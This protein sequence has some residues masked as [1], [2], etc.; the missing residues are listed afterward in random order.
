MK[1]VAPANT[2]PGPMP[3]TDSREAARIVM[4]EC[5]ALPFLPEL[6]ERGP[7]G[8]QQGRTLAMLADLPVDVSPRGWR[9]ADSP[10]RLAR[11]AVD[12]LD[13]DCDALE[14][15]DEQA[16]DP[17][18]EP[19]SSQRLLQVRV[20]GPWSLSAGFELPGGLPT[21]TDRGARRDVAESLAQ[22]VASRATEL[23]GRLRAGTRVI[24]DEPMLWRVAAGTVPAPSHFDP[25]RAVPA[26]QLALALCRFG[27]AL[28]AAGVDHV[29]L[30]VPTTSG[31]DAPALFTS[32]SEP[33][34][35][36]T[37][38]D[39]L[40]LAGEMLYAARSHEALDA[41]GTVLGDG[42][43]L[44]LEGTAD[45]ARVPHT[46]AEAEQAAYDL[47]GLLDRLAAPRYES[48]GR[49]TLS[50]TVEQVTG[51]AAAAARALAGSRLVA[52]TAL[53]IAE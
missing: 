16:R 25:V 18:A 26:D 43:L 34:R 29:L 49:L 35:G 28:R 4:G 33:P 41:A 37:P 1:S 9:L 17:E 2:G 13:R 20:M 51:G 31:P 5:H 11:R 19:P 8:D 27:D 45:T 32:F 6:P 10:G 44:H 53:R 38:L 7:G 23:A 48:L 40:C 39:G 24:L 14:E 21:L 46:T 47:L 22:G 42:R 12:L 52:E 15:A 36:E 3:G 30:R 50:P